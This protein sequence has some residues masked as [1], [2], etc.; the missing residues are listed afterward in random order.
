[1]IMTTT[2]TKCSGELASVSSGVSSLKVSSHRR[3]WTGLTCAEHGQ[4]CDLVAATSRS[5]LQLDSP[6]HF[7]RAD[8]YG[9]LRISVSR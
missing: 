2:W 4:S 5:L 7:S 3:D 9:P 6:V 8:V 1:M